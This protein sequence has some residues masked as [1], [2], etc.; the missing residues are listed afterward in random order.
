M[1]RRWHGMVN[2]GLDSGQMRVVLEAPLRSGYR[3]ATVPLP[4]VNPGG[5]AS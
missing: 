1:G 3:S 2:F 4:P 5:G